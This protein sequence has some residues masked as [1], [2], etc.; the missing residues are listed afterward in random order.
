MHEIRQIRGTGTNG[1]IRKSDI[2]LY[3]KSRKYPLQDG[4]P[5]PSDG[6]R[7]SISFHNPFSDFQPP[8]VSYDPD[9]DR[10]ESMD[11]M[12]EMIAGHMVYSMQTAPHV[13][14]YA[15]VDLTKVVEWRN[16]VKQAFLDNHGV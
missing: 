1:R 6:R 13:T 11:R 16:G 12:R 3:L 8:S 5:P 7:G 9:V 15:E 4:S 10:I 14:C 2:Q